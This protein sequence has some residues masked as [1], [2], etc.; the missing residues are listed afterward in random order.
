MFPLAFRDF[1]GGKVEKDQGKHD[2]QMD[3]AQQLGVDDAE[4]GRKINLEEGQ[5]DGDDAGDALQRVS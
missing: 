2:P 4:P 3:G 5:A 1:S